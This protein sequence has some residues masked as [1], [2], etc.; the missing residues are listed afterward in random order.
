MEVILLTSLA[1]VRSF[2]KG[3]KK[4]GLLCHHLCQV[5]WWLWRNVLLGRQWGILQ[6]EGYPSASMAMATATVV[7][8]MAPIWFDW[9]G[10]GRTSTVH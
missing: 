3:C 8:T 4:L 7:A 5:R 1:M 10:G 9:F 2:N 6:V